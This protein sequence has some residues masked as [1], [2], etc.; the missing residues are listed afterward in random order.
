MGTT[1]KQ[2]GLGLLLLGGC[3]LLAATS[4]KKSLD[5]KTDLLS[6][7]KWKITEHS[8]KCYCDPNGL[9]IYTRDLYVT[10]PT[11]E[12]DNYFLFY[13]GGTVEIN[14]G[15]TK[16]NPAN[17]Q[18]YT[19]G[20]SFGNDE[21]KLNFRGKTW[22]LLQLNESKMVISTVVLLGEGETITFGKY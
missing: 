14:E 11:C 20:W 22:N 10:Y 4:C 2:F 1:H 16:C 9:G 18:L 17:A 19:D 8:E 3:F 6:A 5:S 21:T 12:K 7:G 13:K 15:A